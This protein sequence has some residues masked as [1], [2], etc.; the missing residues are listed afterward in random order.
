MGTI[1]LNT[2]IQAVGQITQDQLVPMGVGLGVM[3]LG[4]MVF[5]IL[6]VFDNKEKKLMKDFL[7]RQN[8]LNKYEDWKKDRK[9]EYD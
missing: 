4:F 9:L 8:L 5:A 6:W 7:R 2:C 1:D 3:A